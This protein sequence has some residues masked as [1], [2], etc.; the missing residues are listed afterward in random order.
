MEIDNKVR[1]IEAVDREVY[2]VSSYVGSVGV[3]TAIDTTF[4]SAEHPMYEV[5]FTRGR[6]EIFWPEELELVS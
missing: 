1:V 4:V 2:D 3:V 5:K 6:R